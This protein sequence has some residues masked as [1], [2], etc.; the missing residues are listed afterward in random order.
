MSVEYWA[1]AVYLVILPRHV[2][3]SIP[4]LNFLEV[5]KSA[6]SKSRNHEMS[7]FVSRFRFARSLLPVFVPVAIST[8]ALQAS[9]LFPFIHPSILTRV[10][11]LPMP[12]HLSL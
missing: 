5:S 1:F 8:L 11:S 4:S 2:S 12:S 3:T 10:Y 9:I 6:V 7:K